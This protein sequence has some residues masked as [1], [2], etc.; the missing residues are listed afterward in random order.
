MNV[1]LCECGK[2]AWFGNY[3]H[4]CRDIAI[5]RVSIRNG[6]PRNYQGTDRTEAPSPHSSYRKPMSPQAVVKLN[7]ES[8]I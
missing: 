2:T 1:K 3:C 8:E 6:L 4:E 7:S 5:R